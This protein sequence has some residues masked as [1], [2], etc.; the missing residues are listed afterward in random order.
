LNKYLITGLGNTGF[1][2]TNTRHNIGFEV[3]DSLAKESGISFSSARYAEVAELKLRNKKLLLIKPTTFMNLS[4]KALN[5]W[6]QQEKI[7]LENS[8]VVVDDVAL[9][10]GAIRLKGKGSDGGHNGLKHI[11]QTLGRQDYA[12]LRFGIGNNYPKGQ[13]I[14]FVLGEWTPEE[15]QAL[16]PRIKEAAAAVK[17]FCLAGIN[18]AMNQHNGQA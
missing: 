18:T 5:Y 3:L 6:L 4:G 16:Q 12:R 9:E 15:T 11:N 14:N 17:T 1:K 8:L 7:P 10:L 13:Q 2:Y